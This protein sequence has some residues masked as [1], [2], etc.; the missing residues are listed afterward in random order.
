METIL[1]WIG[2]IIAY[3]VINFAWRFLIGSAHAAGRAA[4][5]KGNFK[6]NLNA[7]MFGMGKFEVRVRKDVFTNNNKTVDAYFVEAKGVFPLITTKS[8]SF[9]ISV[10]DT[11]DEESQPVFSVLEEFREPRS[12]A[13]Q[14]V[15]N[16]GSV[17]ANQGY[18][19]WTRIGGVL[20]D[21]LETPYK[22]ERELMITIRLIDNNNPPLVHMGFHSDQNGI[23]WMGAKKVK[24]NITYTGYKEEYENRVKGHSLIIKLGVYAAKS[25]NEFADEEGE[26]IKS[27]IQTTLGFYGEKVQGKIKGQLNQ[28]LKETYMDQT[29]HEVSLVKTC[30]ELNAIEIESLKYE[31]VE[32]CYDVIVADKVIKEEE[33]LL[34]KKISNLLNLD[35]DEIQKIKDKKIIKLESSPDSSQSLED[36][37]G[38]TDD[39]TEGQVNSHLRKEF[40]KWNSRLNTLPEGEERENAQRMLDLIASVRN[41]RA[42]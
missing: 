5:G 18:T 13:F 32:L 20:P 33:A 31:A 12:V 8:C 35:Y 15:T 29:D 34:I 40:Q 11:T 17:G 14:T 26:I 39:M 2:I 38:I 1:G 42:A 7:N 16:V 23:L 28:T 36:L 25:D 4:T 24:H 10:L 41:N 30:Q 3:A 22:G 6:E 21:L 27:W 9:M 19:G 37:L